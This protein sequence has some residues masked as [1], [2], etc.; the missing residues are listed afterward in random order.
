M[1]KKSNKKEEKQIDG[2]KEIEP[3]IGPYITKYFQHNAPITRRQQYMDFGIMV[4]ITAG[5]LILAFK[6]IIDGSAATGLIG[7]IVGYV[8][9]H[10]YPKK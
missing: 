3:I 10:I 1:D 9:G 4:F 6:K 8:F 7:V 2:L 5:I